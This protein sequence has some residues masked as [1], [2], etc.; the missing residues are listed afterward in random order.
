[1]C[2]NGLLGLVLHYLFIILHFPISNK[3]KASKSVLPGM[4]LST[5]GVTLRK[6]GEGKYPA[7]GDAQAH[8]YSKTFQPIVST[9]LCALDLQE[10]DGDSQVLENVV[11]TRGDKHFR[12]SGGLSAG[13]SF[14]DHSSQEISGWALRLLRL[15]FAKGAWVTES[16]G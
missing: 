16:R 1:M 10:L 6:E 4:L 8:A 3:S 14:A 2:Q 9:L 5:S 13:T 11:S 7:P 15:Q 12:S